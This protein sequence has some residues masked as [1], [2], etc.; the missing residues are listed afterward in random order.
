MTSVLVSLDSNERPLQQPARHSNCSAKSVETAARMDQSKTPRDPKMIV[1]H[2]YDQIAETYHGR[3]G[4]YWRDIFLLHRR[5]WNRFRLSRPSL[6]QRELNSSR[7]CERSNPALA[8]RKES[9]I[10]SS[11]VLLT[12]TWVGLGDPIF[13][14]EGPEAPVLR[15]RSALSARSAHHVAR[16]ANHLRSKILSSP[17]A[18]N[19]LRPFQKYNSC[20]CDPAS[21]AKPCSPVAPT[22]APGSFAFWGLCNIAGDLPDVSTDFGKA[23]DAPPATTRYSAWGCFRNL[24]CKGGGGHASHV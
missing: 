10:A 12:M 18:R 2:G 17:R 1:A 11:Q 23:V 7:H 20:S 22:L 13:A 15:N 24:G 21:P 8:R 9:W 16:R 3:F 14:R 19:S 5:N 6:W 4:K